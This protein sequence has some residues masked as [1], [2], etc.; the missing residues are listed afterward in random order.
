MALNVSKEEINILVG[1]RR[2]ENYSLSFLY[3]STTFGGFTLNCKVVLFRFLLFEQSFW[4]PISCQFSMCLIIYINYYPWKCRK[5]M[6]LQK[7]LMDNVMHIPQGLSLVFQFTVNIT[8]S[9]SELGQVETLNNI[10]CAK[11]KLSF[12]MVWAYMWLACFYK[13]VYSLDGDECNI[14]T[15]LRRS[16]ALGKSSH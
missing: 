2:E 13:Q 14:R 5:C 6:N 3:F 10:S 9:T 7:S 12:S 11:F 16:S 8:S 15:G 4:R 1:K